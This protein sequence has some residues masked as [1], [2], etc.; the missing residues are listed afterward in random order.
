MLPESSVATTH[1]ADK[2]MHKKLQ[3]LVYVPVQHMACFNQKAF[4]NP[5]TS[6]TADPAGQLFSRFS[7]R[8]A[9]CTT[10]CKSLTGAARMAAGGHLSSA[11]QAPMLADPALKLSPA[12]RSAFKLLALTTISDDPRAISSKLELGI[13][14]C[15]KASANFTACSGF[16]SQNL[17][18]WC[19]DWA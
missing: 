5:R 6:C 13:S 8:C 12:F 10:P 15:E 14:F 2:L 9:I 16:L 18:L 19:S 4:E 11:P 1:T 17:P 7:V 3:H